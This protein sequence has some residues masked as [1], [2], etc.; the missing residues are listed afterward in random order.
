MPLSR[1]GQTDVPEDWRDREFLIELRH[2]RGLNARTIAYE[3]DID[4]TEL[5]VW[6][7]KHNVVRPWQ[8]KEWLAEKIAEHTMISKDTLIQGQPFETLEDQAFNHAIDNIM[9]LPE[10]NCSLRTVYKWSRRHGFVAEDPDVSDIHRCRDKLDMSVSDIADRY[11]MNESD[12]KN[13]LRHNT[14]LD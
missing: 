14:P 6:M 3:L 7:S 5:S 12:V 4:Q 8:D 1:I 13:A 10:M 9:E 2:E 11:G